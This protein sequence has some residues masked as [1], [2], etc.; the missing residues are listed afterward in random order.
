MYISSL[1]QYQQQQLPQQKTVATHKTAL[2]SAKATIQTHTIVVSTG[3]AW[4][5]AVSTRYVQKTSCMNQTRCGATLLIWSPVETD[6][7]VMNVTVIV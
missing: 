1:H 2:S 5:G 7:S 3:T 4:Q 6:L